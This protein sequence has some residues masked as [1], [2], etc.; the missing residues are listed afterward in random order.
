[1][2]RGMKLTHFCIPL[3][4]SGPKGPV[5]AVVPFRTAYSSPRT[6]AFAA[7]E[8]NWYVL[9]S[10]LLPLAGAYIVIR[11][12]IMCGPA[13]TSAVFISSPYPFGELYL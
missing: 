10:L 3:C 9:S 12:S 5:A 13:P 8:V 1:M 6:P 4:V 7:F 2:I 11:V